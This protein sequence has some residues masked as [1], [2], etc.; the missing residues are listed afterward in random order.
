[1][2]RGLGAGIFGWIEDIAGVAERGGVSVPG[3]GGGIA[4]SLEGP[5]A[6][7]VVG[8]YEIAEVR[9]KENSGCR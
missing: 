7:G 3:S 5:G 1:M 6:T 8:K 2:H 4:R 9:V